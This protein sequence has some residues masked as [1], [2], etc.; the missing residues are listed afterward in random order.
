MLAQ[1]VQLQRGHDAESSKCVQCVRLPQPSGLCKLAPVLT[2]TFMAASMD[3]ASSVESWHWPFGLARLVA[4]RASSILLPAPAEQGQRV[5]SMTSRR[6]SLATRLHAYAIRPNT[7]EYAV[8]S[9]QRA[10]VCD[11]CK[12]RACDGRWRR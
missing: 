10:R 5:R 12:R 8:P 9:A 11:A 4:R 7:A 6:T 3:M 2:R 1:T